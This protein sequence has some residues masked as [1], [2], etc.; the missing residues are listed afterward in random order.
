MNFEIGKTYRIEPEYKKTLIEKEIVVSKNDPSRQIMMTT[1]WRGGTFCITPVYQEDIESLEQAV[2][3]WSPICLNDLTEFECVDTFDGCHVDIEFLDTYEWTEE[4]K[5]QI[6][7]NYE[8]FFEWYYDRNGDG[9]DIEI[10]DFDHTSFFINGT[11][12]VALEN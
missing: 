11:I 2:S 10:F 8:E 4:E 12:M 6:L 5:T 3:G 7:E 1:V 9:K